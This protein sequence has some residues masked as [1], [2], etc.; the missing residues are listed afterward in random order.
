MMSRIT[1]EKVWNGYILSGSS[2]K[3]VYSELAEVLVRIVN[4]YS[5]TIYSPQW[6]DGLEDRMK[7][8]LNGPKT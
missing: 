8:A 2:Q 5:S 4:I 6:L 7:A 1:I 3:E